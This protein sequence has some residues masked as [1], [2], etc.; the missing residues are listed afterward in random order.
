MR[1]FIILLFISLDL[2]VK[3]LPQNLNANVLDM[4]ASYLMGLIYSNMKTHKSSNSSTGNYLMLSE[5]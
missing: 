5:Y 4:L 2:N 3:C 1:N